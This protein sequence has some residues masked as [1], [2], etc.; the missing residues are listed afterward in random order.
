VARTLPH[1]CV[2]I[3]RTNI[4]QSARCSS[5]SRVEACIGDIRT[6]LSLLVR[7]SSPHVRKTPQGSGVFPAEAVSET[8]ILCILGTFGIPSAGGRNDRLSHEGTE[9]R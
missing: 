2:I 6:A 4:L 8:A 3:L 9:S 7:G 5:Y 1:R